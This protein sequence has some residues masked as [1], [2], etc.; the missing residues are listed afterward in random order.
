MKPAFG[1]DSTSLPVVA[2]LHHVFFEKSET[3][4]YNT[5]AHMRRFYP[6]YV[7]WEFRNLDQFPL[8][9]ADCHSLAAARG[10]RHWL[11]QGMTR[12]LLGRELS[13]ERFLKLRQ[14]RLL[15]AHFGHN[16]VWALRLKRALQLPLVTTFY[17]H[18]MSQASSLASWEKGYRLL[19][20][21]GDLFLVEGPHML[22]RLNEIGCPA[23]KI[24]IQRI[25]I[26]LNRLPFR[27]RFPKKKGEKTIIVFSGRFVEK[28]GLLIALQA[29]RDV[30]QKH[31]VFEFRIIGDGPL[32]PEVEQFIQSHKMNPYVRLLGFL[33]YN[34]YLEQMKN[35]DLFLHPSNTA[36]DGDSEGGAPTTILE[37]QAMGL[38]V[39]STRHADIP[40]VVN[41]GQSALLSGERDSD[42]LAAN[43]TRLL[44]DQQCWPQMGAAGRR[45]IETFHD[46][47]KEIPRLESIYSSLID[48]HVD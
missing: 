37:A 33:N 45:F 31:P 16:G 1:N 12:R 11:L 17:G 29:L 8:A 9:A 38:P 10:S 20:K 6:L 30:Q 26:P 48:T 34:D 21:E 43:I 18:D 4:I 22:K 42:E 47:N 46:V 3:F 5:I 27:S 39:L 32:K 7:A 2:H 13:T 28:K 44:V 41:P 19:F 15:H 14:V 36:V 25:A 35:A 24:E 23:D 40:N